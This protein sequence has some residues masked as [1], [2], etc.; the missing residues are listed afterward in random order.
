MRKQFERRANRFSALA[1]VVV[2]AFLVLGDSSAWIILIPVLVAFWVIIH[3]V[4]QD[5]ATVAEER[6]PLQPFNI[7]SRISNLP[8]EE[9]HRDNSSSA[10]GPESPADERLDVNGGT[11]I[12]SLPR[13]ERSETGHPPT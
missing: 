6:Q 9:E 3:L 10:C 1:G 7:L 4:F 8:A 11:N 12:V 13:R 5:M 2:L